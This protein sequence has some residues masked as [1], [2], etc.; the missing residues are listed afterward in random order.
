MLAQQFAMLGS[1]A[2][3]GPMIRFQPPSAE[4][5]PLGSLVEFIYREHAMFPFDR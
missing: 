2:A 4:H 1:L 3:C 5:F